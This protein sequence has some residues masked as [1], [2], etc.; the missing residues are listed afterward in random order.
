MH[1]LNINSTLRV[2]YIK[3]K[4]EIFNCIGGLTKRSLL[5]YYR[6]YDNAQTNRAINFKSLQRPSMHFGIKMSQKT[7]IEITVKIWIFDKVYACIMLSQTKY[8]KN[9]T[10]SHDLFWYYCY[11]IVCY[12]NIFCD[13]SDISIFILYS[14]YKFCCQPELL[15]GLGVQQQVRI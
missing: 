8:F 10:L 14:V 3:E 7:R 11:I 12:I 9:C 5:N 15:T 6:F 2:Q 4:I 1:Y 13:W